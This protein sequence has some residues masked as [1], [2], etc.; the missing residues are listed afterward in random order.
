VSAVVEM[1]AQ[2]ARLAERARAQ[3]ETLS[4]L[5]GADLD[6]AGTL[7]DVIDRAR[8]TFGME[9]VAL[10]VRD[11]ASG[12][13]SEV[14][15]TGWSA[16][17]KEAPMQFD[18]PIGRELRLIGRG[19]P[20]FA[21]DQRVLHAFAAASETAYEARRLSQE[22][23]Q[24]RELALVD[25]QRTALLAAVG[26]DLRTPLAGIKAAVSS[27]R[28]RDVT[29]SDA[30]RDE[31]LAT[32][33][34]SAD[35][36][37][38]VVANLLDASRLEAGAVSVHARAVALDE[39]VAAA[40]LAVPSADAR[41]EID[42]ADDLPLVL[43]D[44]G[45]LERVVAN[46]VDNALRHGEGTITLAARRTSGYVEL[47]VVDEGRGF[48]DDIAARAFERFAR[49]DLARSRGGTGLGMAIVRGVAEAHGGRAD[50]VP[51]PGARVRITLREAA[52]FSNPE[53][54]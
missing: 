42:V 26:H 52:A 54:R 51:G 24:A 32:I 6:E 14:E 30:D 9:S 18:V 5:A 34:E 49:G 20:Q 10:L 33:E 22:A 47:E 48:G 45:L 23:R 4:Q 37:D 13:W 31:L 36:L 27:L 7:H 41:V 15:R 8:R 38:A 28:G 25:R 3:A 35:R 43:A 16:P 29:W 2:R 1:S 21:E 40:V 50:I 11:R 12:E 17:G 46:L 44:P 39:V 19:P 53:L